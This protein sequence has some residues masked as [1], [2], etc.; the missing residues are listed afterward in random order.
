MAAKWSCLVIRADC[1]MAGDQ[2]LASRSHINVV[3]T[4]NIAA[5]ATDPLACAGFS[6]ILLIQRTLGPGDVAELAQ[7]QILGI[8]SRTKLTAQLLDRAPELLTVG[9]FSVGTSQVDLDAAR[10]RGIPVFNTPFSNTRSVAE[11]TIGEIVMLL[12][13]IPQRSIAAHAGGWT[14]PHTALSKFV[15]RRLKSS[16]TRIS[17]RGSRTLPRPW[18]CG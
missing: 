10:A 15:A 8:R 12:R 7:A 2:N 16:A 3:L 14:S 1:D 18:A 9:C 4:E 11:L 5:S 17:A 6:A 13:R